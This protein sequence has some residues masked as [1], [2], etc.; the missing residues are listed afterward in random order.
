MSLDEIGLWASIISVE[1]EN[2]TSG[3][4]IVPSQELSLFFRKCGTAITPESVAKT[5]ENI[6]GGEI[7]FHFQINL[8]G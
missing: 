2:M 6:V 1:F 4:N 3:T 5:R 7:I 8:P